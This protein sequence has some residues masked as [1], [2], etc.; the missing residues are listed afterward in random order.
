M[1]IEDSKKIDSLNN[2]IT[3]N[4]NEIDFLKLQEKNHR[5]KKETGK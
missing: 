5:R 4:L 2:E 3:L 1:A